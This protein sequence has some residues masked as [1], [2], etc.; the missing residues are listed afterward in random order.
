MIEVRFHGRGGQGVKIAS[1]ILG[2]SGFLAGLYS[3][4]FALFG[5]E[6]RGAPVVSFTRLGEQPID[7]RGYIDTPTLIVLM[8]HS[9]LREAPD[10]IFYGVDAATPFF[11]NGN[12]NNSGIANQEMPAANFVFIDL[13]AI[14]RRIMGRAFV[15]AA[16]AAVVAK[17][18]PTIPLEAVI[19]AVRSEFADFGMTQE[20]VEENEKAAREVYGLVPAVVLSSRVARSKQVGPALESIPYP[21]APQFIVPAIRRRGS[22]AL[23]HTGS[24]RIER[25]EI[26]LG[27]CKRC[28]LCY[29]YCPDAAVQLDAENYPHLDYDHCKGCMICF[30]ECPTQAIARRVEA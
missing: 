3:Q 13:S 28:F 14:C 23:R 21:N 4:D 27:K 20:L 22:A 30:A 11:I 1:R 19:E 25:P 9:L 15:S 17:S 10:Q 18:I 6:R 12:A 8:D 26:D 16:A 5:A 29:L 7:T 24:W 2:R